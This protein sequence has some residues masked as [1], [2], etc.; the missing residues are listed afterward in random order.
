M[1]RHR[2]AVV[3]GGVSGLVAVY[4]LR[5]LLGLEAELHLFEAHEVLGGKLASGALGG[6]TVELGA[7]AFVVR[8]PEVPALLAELG[9]EG[10]RVAP[11]AA[12]PL[13]WSGGRGHTLPGGT[14]MGIPVA[15]ESV[16]GLVDEATVA[17]LQAEPLRPFA[18][19]RGQDISV[20]ELVGDRFGA[21]VV[22]R[23]VDPLL[24]GVYAGDSATIG[25]RAALPGLAKALDEGAQSLTAAVATALPPPLPGP[26]F[27]TLRGGYQVL[28][29]ALR[30]RAQ[31]LVTTGRPVP[32]IT[33][34]DRGWA[35][36]GAGVFDGIVLAVPAREVARLLAGIAPGASAAAAGIGAADSALVSLE[37]PH[38]TELPEHSGVLVATGEPLAAKAFTFTSR[39]W[40]HLA[41]R[42]LLRASFG[43]YG[44]RVERS[45]GELVE[46]ALADLATIS[47]IGARPV[48]A[49]VQW[50]RGGL[51]QYA[52]GHCDTVTAIEE[53]VAGLPG[54][55]V[56]GAYLHGV[57]VPACVG[58]GDGAARRL[59]ATL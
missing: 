3:G 6:G 33:R 57:G 18:W 1:V 25:V 26:V 31:A 23:S 13:I 20:A 27:G 15:A 4:R 40:P 11:S 37:L 22:H 21:Q 34:L 46:A 28:L 47:G 7:E 44:E 42:V 52:P 12:R 14:L 59:V 2:V 51:P 16:R 58:S 48:A 39:K 35:I 9:L 45:D 43:R 29:A 17:Q 49:R 55:E 10:Q 5:R 38:G 32:A 54:L 56:A 36:G 8:R 19:R 24:G 41:G 50:W 53:A 30:D